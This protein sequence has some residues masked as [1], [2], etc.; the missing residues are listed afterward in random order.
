M[1]SDNRFSGGDGYEWAS[2][3]DGDHFFYPDATSPDGNYNLGLNPFTET[4]K[5]LPTPPG[6][7]ISS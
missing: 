1:S 2:Q 5:I 4:W 3:G 6:A 7:A